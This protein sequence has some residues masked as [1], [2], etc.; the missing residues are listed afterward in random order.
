MKVLRLPASSHWSYQASN[1]SSSNELVL[2]P[3]VRF[4]VSD[5]ELALS[6]FHSCFAYTTITYDVKVNPW[7]ACLPSIHE[8]V[9]CA[10]YAAIALAQR[11]QGHLQQKPE[12]TSILRLKSKALSLFASKLEDLSFEGGL[13]TALLLI[14]LDYAESGVS[15]WIIHLQGAYRILESHG[16]IALAE[17]R[18]NVRAQL[19]MLLWYDVS[20]ALLSRCGPV[21]PRSYVQALMEWQDDREW[22]MLAL[23]GL[24]DGMF[25]DMHELAQTAAL[26]KNTDFENVDAVIDRISA[27]KILPGVD[28]HQAS[29]CH[30]WKLFLLLYC[31]RVFPRSSRLSPAVE[32]TVESH[33]EDTNPHSLGMKILGIVAEIPDDS[34]YQKQCLLPI[35]VA[36]CEISAASLP[37]RKIALRYAEVWKE[38]SGMWVF[39]S[40]LQFMGG[41]WARNDTHSVGGEVDDT[42]QQWVPWTEVYLPSAGHGFLLA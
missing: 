34:N 12:G 15:N 9:P 30:V 31:A 4:N 32:E 36:A 41:V 17:S 29:M 25:L 1:T 10:R 26:R 6:C 24:P 23:N 5:V 42:S 28:R 19:A 39:K 40:C 21:F 27:V 35:I 13:S 37:Y 18:P 38:R 33:H 11:Q 8:D 3:R 14:A 7:N 16:G 22:S 20:A 2:S